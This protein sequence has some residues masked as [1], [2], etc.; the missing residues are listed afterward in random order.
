MRVQYDLSSFQKVFG[1]LARPLST[2]NARDSSSEMVLHVAAQSAE[3]KWFS[4]LQILSDGYLLYH[5]STRQ[6]WQPTVT[7]SY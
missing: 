7:L 6:Y 2:V 3:G 1:N 5:R 4:T